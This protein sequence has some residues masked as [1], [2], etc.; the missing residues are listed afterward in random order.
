MT[1]LGTEGAWEWGALTR[2]EFGAGALARAERTPAVMHADRHA[3]SASTLGLESRSAGAGTSSSDT[4]L[5]TDRPRL[6]LAP[7]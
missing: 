3:G 6:V 7:A 5:A 2:R 1:T 4:S